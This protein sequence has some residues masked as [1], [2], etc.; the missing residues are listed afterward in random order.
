MFAVFINDLP[1]CVSSS[2]SYLFADDTKCLKV[3]SNLADIQ[4]LQEDLDNL[5]NW[6]HAKKLLFN[7][8]K[9]THL[10]FGKNLASTHIQ[11]MAQTSQLQTVLRIWEYSYLSTNIN[12]RHHYEKLIADAY[13]MLGLLRRT[14]TTPCIY[15]RKQLYLTLVRSQMMYSSQLWRP[16][17]LKD[18]EILEQVQRRATKFILNNY[19]ISYKCRLIQLNL[20]PLMYQ[21]ELNDLLF[22]IKSY[23]ASNTHF[24]INQFVHFRSSSTRSSAASKLVHQVSYSKLISIFFCRITRLWN[25][26]PQIDITLPPWNN[27]IRY[28]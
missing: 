27:L 16:F 13:R 9:S 3:I 28:L 4:V 26:L 22:F 6:S 20:L 1:N 2:T 25:A 7:E 11:S 21:Y 12:F 19:I 15:A 5:S 17:L 23:K 24:D 14:F 8:S 18:I 10:H